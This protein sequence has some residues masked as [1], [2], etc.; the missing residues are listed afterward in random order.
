MLTLEE[1]VRHLS[2]TPARRLGLGDRGLVEEGR[3]ADLV[4]F[5]PATV[6]DTATFAEP[7][8]VARGIHVVVVNG[9]VAWRDGE[10]TD[11]AAGRVLR[12]GRGAVG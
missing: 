11:A 2:A 8:Q 6:H 12:A 9:A 5:D 4:L 7:R 10:R 3:A 1:A